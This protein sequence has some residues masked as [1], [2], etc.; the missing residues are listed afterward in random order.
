MPV[1][2]LPKVI[3]KSMPDIKSG[4]VPLIFKPTTRSGRREPLSTI[5]GSNKI[6]AIM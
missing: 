4:F 2:V 1:A 3:W 5:L 6:K